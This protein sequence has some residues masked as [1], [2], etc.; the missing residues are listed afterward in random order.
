M[1][2]VSTCVINWKASKNKTYLVKLNRTKISCVILYAYELENVLVNDLSIFF[3]KVKFE[4]NKN[5]L[6]I[7]VYITFLYDCYLYI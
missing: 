4:K 5:K 3:I 2:I 6:L 1:I 7:Y